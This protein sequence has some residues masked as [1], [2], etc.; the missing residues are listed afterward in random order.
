MVSWSM[1][2]FKDIVLAMEM[3][4]LWREAPFS[5]MKHKCS[6]TV[7]SVQGTGEPTP[8]DCF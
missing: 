2:Y 5:G 6:K 7:E 3:V 4:E 8:N 1:S